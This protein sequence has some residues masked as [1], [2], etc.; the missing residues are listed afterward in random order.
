MIILIKIFSYSTSVLLVHGVLLVVGS[1]EVSVLPFFL[2]ASRVP[3]DWHYSGVE[4]SRVSIFSPNPIEGINGS[5][6]AQ[7]NDNE[8][9]RDANNSDSFV[10]VPSQGF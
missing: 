6:D 3:N 4:F 10:R 7:D 5:H 9:N 8:D 1:S 2:E